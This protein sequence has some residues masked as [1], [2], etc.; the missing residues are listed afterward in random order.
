MSEAGQGMDANRRKLLIVVGVGFV[1]AAVCTFLFYRML[2]GRLS[3]DGAATQVERNVTVAAAELPRGTRLGPEHLTTQTYQGADLPEGAF[4][5]PVVLAGRVLIRDVGEGE[6]VYAQALAG[7]DDPWLAAEI[8]EGMRGVTVHVTEFAG[9]TQHLQVGDRVDVLV[10]DANRAP[11]RTEM[12]L[13]TLLQNIEVIATGR[14]LKDDGRPNAIPAVTLLVEARD[15]QDL[16]LADQ[17]GAVRLAL[18]NPLDEGT[19]DTRYGQFSDLLTRRDDEARNA[20]RQAESD[21]G[22]GSSTAAE[23]ASAGR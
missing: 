2:S 21:A 10:A 16:N 12:R 22:D 3:S 11:G 1:A 20:R 7:K 9:V 13:K 23:V 18:R 14:E 6:V 5:D 8:P 15:S 4:A 19:Q 17:S